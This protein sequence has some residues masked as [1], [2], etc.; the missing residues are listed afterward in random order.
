MHNWR[1]VGY[2]R[3]YPIKKSFSVQVLFSNR[4]ISATCIKYSVDQISISPGFLIN[5]LTSAFTSSMLVLE[6]LSLSSCIKLS[7]VN[8][9]SG[10]DPSWLVL[11]HRCSKFNAVLFQTYHSKS[12]QSRPFTLFFQLLNS[13]AC[14]FPAYRS[15]KV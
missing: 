8:S 14:I 5:G 4:I 11:W 15:G 1:T 6:I 9:S 12:Y 7:R 2:R 13:N 3:I 10:S